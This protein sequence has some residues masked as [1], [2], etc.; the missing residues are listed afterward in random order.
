METLPRSAVIA[1]KAI[2]KIRIRDI[3]VLVTGTPMRIDAVAAVPAKNV[4]TFG[5][6]FLGCPSGGPSCNKG[7]QVCLPSFSFLRIFVQHTV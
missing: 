1:T 2:P 7:S 5:T 4:A 6:G 3:A